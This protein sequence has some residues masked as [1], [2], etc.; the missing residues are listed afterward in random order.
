MV[1]N[2]IRPVVFFSNANI[3][4]EEEYGK[5]LAEL[6]R[7]AGSF[8]LETVEDEYDHAAWLLAIRGLEACPE[9]GQRCLECFRFRLLRAAQYASGRGIRLLTTTL[10][11]SRW[12][13]LEQVDEAG[14]WACSQVEGVQWWPANWRRGGLQPRRGE[15]IKEQNFYNQNFCGCEFSKAIADGTH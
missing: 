8:G 5:R 1:E 14:R 10:A 13:S 6:K 4:P 3:V 7:Y 12:K 2:G 11:S 9:R 15:I